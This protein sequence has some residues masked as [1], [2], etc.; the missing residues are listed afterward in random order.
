MTLAIFDLDNTLLAGDSDHGWGEFII[1]QGL[2][3][4]EQYR[5]QN[6]RFYQDY[7]NGELDIHA[8]Q[9][10]CLKQLARFEPEHLKALLKH[11]VDDTVETMISKKSEQLIASHR[12]QNHKLLIIT[13]TN[14]IIT[15]PI[16]ERL[17]ISVLI[18]TEA[19]C[20][21]GHPTGKVKGTPSYAGGKIERLD[22]WLAEHP[23]HTLEDS[24]FY[25]DSH[26]DIPLLKYVDHPYVVD[27]DETL[28]AYAKEK[29]WPVISL[30]D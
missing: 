28:L 16:A 19:E 30:R 13:A 22:Q 1:S 7:L 27:P 21:Q 8:Y 10:F 20:K 29:H 4:A 17:G 11:F 9:S 3:D 5:Q 15:R 14:E 23:E 24:Y 25:S 26:N 2:V 12:D 6:D 18:A